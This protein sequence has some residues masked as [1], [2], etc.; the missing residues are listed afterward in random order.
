M[1]LPA[2]QVPKMKRWMLQHGMLNWIPADDAVLRL[3]AEWLV[4][5]SF[6]W[7]KIILI[8]AQL[9][10]LPDRSILKSSPCTETKSMKIGET[11]GW[12]WRCH[13]FPCSHTLQRSWSNRNTSQGKFEFFPSFIHVQYSNKKLAGG[14]IRRA[15]DIRIKVPSKKNP[16]EMKEYI[17]RG[18]YYNK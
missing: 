16:D 18:N 13:R 1:N 7:L 8:F 5:V 10:R 6:H 12:M 11:T 3:S 9:N 15:D 14:L 4:N 17:I 2:F